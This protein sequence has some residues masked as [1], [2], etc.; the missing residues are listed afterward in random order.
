MTASTVSSA[1]S[2]ASTAGAVPSVTRLGTSTSSSTRNSFAG[3]STVAL[4]LVPP[5]SMPTTTQAAFV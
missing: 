3:V 1:D 2:I 4:L 5:L